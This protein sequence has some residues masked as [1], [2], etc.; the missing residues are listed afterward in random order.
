MEMEIKGWLAP[1]DREYPCAQRPTPL[2]PDVKQ[3]SDV[4][5]PLWILTVLLGLHYF[6]E[7]IGARQT[8]SVQVR[9]SRLEDVVG[10][11]EMIGAMCPRSIFVK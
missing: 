3:V 6:L 4:A 1:R 11:V 8:A 10:L 9:E 7:A 2:R 5:E